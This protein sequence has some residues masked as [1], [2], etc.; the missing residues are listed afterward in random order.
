MAN[1]TII[2]SGKTQRI[3]GR[4]RLVDGMVPRVPL[5]KPLKPLGGKYSKGVDCI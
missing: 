2:D 1:A 5:G 3:L 4:N